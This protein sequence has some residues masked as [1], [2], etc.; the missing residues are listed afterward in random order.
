M[1]TLDLVSHLKLLKQQLKLPGMTDNLDRR[2]LN[3][4][5]AFFHEDSHRF[6]KDILD[7]FL[8]VEIGSG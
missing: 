1:L 8:E 5:G 3:L 4:S 2:A 6:G 7:A